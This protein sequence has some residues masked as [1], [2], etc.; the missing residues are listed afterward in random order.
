MPPNS[1]DT[2]FTVVD[3]FWIRILPTSVEPV[4][5]IFLTSGLAQ[6]SS[7]ISPAEPVTMLITP[8]GK[9]AS[10]ASTPKAS[11]E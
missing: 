9:P 6:I 7:P 11:A 4:K 8:F 2:F 3:D 10:S 5:V 1:I